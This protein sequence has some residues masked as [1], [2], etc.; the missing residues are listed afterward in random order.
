MSIDA[1]GVER[2]QEGHPT[3]KTLFAHDII[4]IE[5]LTFKEVETGTYFI[6]VAPLKLMDTDASPARVLLFQ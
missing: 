5:G 4:V 3:H 6:V 2:A 1:L